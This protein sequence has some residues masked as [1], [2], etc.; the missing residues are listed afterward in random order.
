M[1]I[2]KQMFHYTNVHRFNINNRF[3]IVNITAYNVKN[4]VKVSNP[5]LL[6]A[7]K[8]SLLNHKGLKLSVGNLYSR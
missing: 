8:L 2:I 4:I 5:K 1:M 7:G 3:S 6:H